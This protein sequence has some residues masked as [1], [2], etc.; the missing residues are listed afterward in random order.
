MEASADPAEPPHGIKRSLDSSGDIKSPKRGRKKPRKEATIK[1]VPKELE[2]LA[3]IPHAEWSLIF[4]IFSTYFDGIFMHSEV[5]CPLLEAC[6]GLTRSLC[7]VQLSAAALCIAA[8]SL[9]LYNLI[10]LRLI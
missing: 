9:T 5:L 10:G 8:H 1:Y 3:K 2:E 4:H 6:G 7:L